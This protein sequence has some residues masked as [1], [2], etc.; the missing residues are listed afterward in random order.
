MAAGVA[1]IAGIP[2]RSI[3]LVILYFTSSNV[4]QSAF[5]AF[6]DHEPTRHHARQES[7]A[8]IRHAKASE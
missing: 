1:G 8:N 7:N 2:F 3:C 5:H 6:A 4:V